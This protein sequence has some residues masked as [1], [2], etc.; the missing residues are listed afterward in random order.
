MF[1]MFQQ[2]AS[3][4]TSP[5][6]HGAYRSLIHDDEMQVVGDGPKPPL[7]R[8]PRDPDGPRWP[9]TAAR[10]MGST[11]KPGKNRECG[12]CLI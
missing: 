6:I 10:R 9:P 3:S 1:W 4:Q 5:N 11:K 7:P 2:S 8:I 12:E